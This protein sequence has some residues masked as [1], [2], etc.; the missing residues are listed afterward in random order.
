MLD[1]LHNAGY[2]K[3]YNEFREE[4]PELVGLYTD[5]VR[6]GNTYQAY[7]LSMILLPILRLQQVGY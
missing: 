7:I 4:A 1:Y 3:T 5:C 2:I 6:S